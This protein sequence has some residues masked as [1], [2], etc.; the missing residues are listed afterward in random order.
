M[1]GYKYKSNDKG[2]PVPMIEEVTGNG[3]IENEGLVP[4]SVRML[5]D[6]IGSET[7]M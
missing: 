7:G 6:L 2:M 3:P 1:E 4:R 5:F